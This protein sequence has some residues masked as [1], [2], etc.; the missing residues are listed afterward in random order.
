[1]QANLTHSAGRLCVETPEASSRLWGQLRKDQGSK[2]QRSRSEGGAWEDAA[3]G[4]GGRNLLGFRERSSRAGR[5]RAAN[6]Q[7]QLTAGGNPRTHAQNHPEA[8]RVDFSR[9]LKQAFE[10]MTGT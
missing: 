3:S 9:E 7:L 6:K 10:S 2:E 4:S 5:H 1:M 8:P